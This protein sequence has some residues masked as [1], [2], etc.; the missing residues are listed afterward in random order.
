MEKNLQLVSGNEKA[1]TL[2][3]KFGQ[4][5]FGRLLAVKIVVLS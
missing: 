1:E 4:F 5:V 3:L 2:R